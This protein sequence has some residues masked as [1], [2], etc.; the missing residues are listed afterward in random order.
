MGAY[1]R[2]WGE[3]SYR[4]AWEVRGPS[5]TRELGR[6]AVLVAVL[7]MGT[8]I[9]YVTG[10][11]RF[12][13]P[14]LMLIPVLLA[15]A[16]Y[17]LPGALMAALLAGLAMAA[18]PLNVATGEAQGTLNWLIRLGLYLVIG[19]FAGW[20]FSRLRNTHAERDVA[21]RTDPRVGLPNQV[22]ME[23]DL[24]GLLAD[25]QCRDGKTV[26]LILVR[27]ADITDILE[28][29]GADASD[30]LVS[31]MSRRIARLDG[32]RGIYRYSAA[33]LMLLLWPVDRDGLELAAERLVE[34]G[35]D[36]LPVK[37]IPARVQL[38][39]GSSLPEESRSPE[40]LVREARMALLAAAEMHRSHCHYR[41]EFT[42][43]TVQTIKMIASVRHGLEQGEF[44]LHYQPKL[45]LADASV[46]GCEALIRWRGE[47]GR[48]IPPGLFM[49]KVENTTLIEPVTRF[50]AS[51]ACGFAKRFAGTVSINVS[52]RNLQDASLLGEIEALI[53][54]TGLMPS[55]LEVEI[56]ETALM[57]DLTAARQ[58]LARLRSFGI[59]VSIDD[60][61]TGFASFEYLRHLPIT[62]LKIDRAFVDGLGDDERSRKLMACL[63]DVGHALGLEVTAEGVE[64]QEQHG[65]LRE[66]GCDLAQGFLYTKALPAEQLLAWQRDHAAKIDA[67]RS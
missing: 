55:Q 2:L 46:C 31:A 57:N 49:P 1:S 15:A 6:V 34:L 61:G 32:V 4:P 33:E 60:F 52:A 63:I 64:T 12:S 8:L 37:G 65:I 27:I 7:A 40:E 11:T 41:P 45:R 35:E 47:D 43:R 28:A 51:E 62:G 23:E 22:A 17:G 26:G 30:E 10:G 42:Q 44:L 24:A 66:L 58:A 48:L 54:R 5:F 20:L 56:T 18:T 25:S 16:W 59:G 29:M 21:A 53:E 14:Y 39:L 38:V 36:N 13:Y 3:R 50:V 19:G 67:S 9:V